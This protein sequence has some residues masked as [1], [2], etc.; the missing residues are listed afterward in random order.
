[1][2]IL[3]SSMWINI[4]L[5]FS[6]VK[7]FPCFYLQNL[8]WPRIYLYRCLCNQAY[9]PIP[10]PSPFLYLHLHLYLSFVIC[11]KYFSLV[12]TKDWVCWLE[13]TISSDLPPF[14]L[15]SNG[16]NL[17]RYTLIFDAVTLKP[18]LWKKGLCF[19]I[20]SVQGTSFQ[21]NLQF[22]PFFKHTN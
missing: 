8:V 14:S 2:N 11:I 5:F 17:K 9:I 15:V 18:Q 20:F 6:I 3:H 7:R 10:S 12:C 19:F 21:T 16:N 13:V 1:M 22:I 4:F